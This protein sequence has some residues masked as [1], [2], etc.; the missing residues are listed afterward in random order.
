M[1]PLGFRTDIKA[2]RRAGLDYWQN[3]DLVEHADLE[4]FLAWAE[5]RPLFLYSSHGTALYTE[6]EVPRGGVLVF[7]P[8][9]VGLPRELVDRLGAWRVPVR[10]EVRSLNLSNAVAVVAYQ[11][12]ARLQPS[13]WGPASKAPA[14]GALE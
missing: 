9:S 11:A 7:G 1:H 2:V 10:G 13:W 8:E 5:G 3:V 4:A 14:Q 12:V 6:A